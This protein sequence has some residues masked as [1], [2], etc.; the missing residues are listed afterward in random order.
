MTT[1]S[2][3]RGLGGL[4][5]P[6]L[7]QMRSLRVILLASLLAAS[8]APASALTTT[9]GDHIDT[10]GASGHEWQ[11][12]ARCRGAKIRAMQ[13]SLILGFDISVKNTAGNKMQFFAYEAFHDGEPYARVPS[14]SVTKTGTVGDS[15]G[16]ESARGFDLL[17]SAQKFYV[18][19]ACWDEGG[20]AGYRG[21][22]KVAPQDISFGEYVGGAYFDG[23]SVP[24]VSFRPA[25]AT[26][27]YLVRV[28]SADIGPRG[29][30]VSF[31]DT[32]PFLSDPARGRPGVG[33]DDDDPEEPET[34]PA[35]PEPDSDTPS[36]GHEG[37]SCIITAPGACS[38][39]S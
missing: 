15:Y 18:L 8:A 5:V 28:H 20:E 10:V 6:G 11:G 22:A 13:D 3:L 34:G 37:G 7:L 9:D 36:Y 30:Y 23:G 27:D 19:L 38:D 35:Q 21:A 31:H 12:S 14:A 33:L 4:R 39:P 29:N 24:P 1:I 16:W 25:T 2:T 32:D 26:H 17:V